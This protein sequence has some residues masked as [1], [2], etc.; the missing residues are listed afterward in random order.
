MS[1]VFDGQIFDDFAELPDLGSL[2]GTGTATMR[3]YEGKYKDK[4]KLPKYDSLETG[5][6]ALL[7]DE[8]TFRFFKY[9]ADS[10]TWEGNGEVI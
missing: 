3:R 7:S 6:S 8:G 4:N 10:K 1:K 2:V 5:C 9:Y